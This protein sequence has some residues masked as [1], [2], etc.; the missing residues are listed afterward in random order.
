MDR[1]LS[2]AELI[3]RWMMRLGG[4][5][6]LLIAFVIAAE[7][8]MR[9]FFGITL[10]G[11]DEISGQV[12]AVSSTWAFAFALLQKAHV[13]IDTLYLA[14][15]RRLRPW[16]DVTALLVLGAF[17]G[18]LTWYAADML[19]FTF[20]FDTRSLSLLS[21]PMWIPQGAWVVGLI[22][23]FLVITLL[24]LRTLLA[25]VAGDRD[26][27]LR[28]AGLASVEDEIKDELADLRRRGSGSSGGSR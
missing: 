26:T 19:R 24:L 17:V 7:I 2:H 6:I 11:V 14:L 23:F 9:R 12:L 3:C 10:G 28:L 25:L 16:L 15:P 21:T 18:L 8:V 1:A 13:R 4:A 5:M 27:A 20:A 22:A